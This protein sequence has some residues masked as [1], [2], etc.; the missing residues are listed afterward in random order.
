M[1][2]AR[3]RDRDLFRRAIALERKR[4]AE[5][6]DELASQASDVCMTEWANAYRN[7]ATKI[8]GKAG[9]I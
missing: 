2:E 4:C 3:A 1:S 8:R 9:K 5:L 6:C 7:A